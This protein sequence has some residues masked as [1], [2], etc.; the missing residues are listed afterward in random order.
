MKRNLMS[1]SRQAIPRMMAVATWHIN[2][3]YTGFGVGPCRRQA[4]REDEVSTVFHDSR[5]QLDK[6]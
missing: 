6:R 2:L 4:W 3:D 1:E 5:E